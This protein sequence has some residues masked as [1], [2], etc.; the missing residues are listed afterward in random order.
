MLRSR[1]QAVIDKKLNKSDLEREVS[2]II[3]KSVENNNI[4]LLNNYFGNDAHKHY[5]TLAQLAELNVQANKVKMSAFDQLYKQVNTAYLILGFYYAC[6]QGN[7]AVVIYFVEHQRMKGDLDVG[8]GAVQKYLDNKTP[9]NGPPLSLAAAS[10]NFSLVSYLY[11]E[12]DAMIETRL[13]EPTKP[14][15]LM[16]AAS[17]GD[18]RMVQYLLENGGNANAEISYC[19][20]TPLKCAIESGN[21]SV[22][23]RLVNAGAIVTADDVTHAIFYNA[24]IKIISYLLT[25]SLN[26][27]HP[28]H[29]YLIT[30]IRSGNIDLLKYFE[31]LPLYNN[32][33]KIASCDDEPLERRMLAAA[34]TSGSVAMMRHLVE[35]KKLPLQKIVRGEMMEMDNYLKAN[36]DQP[37]FKHSRQ[38]INKTNETILY[39]ASSRFR[40]N[41][42]NKVYMLRYLFEEQN[43]KPSDRV[44]R[45]LCVMSDY[46]MQCIAYLLS[47]LEQAP[48]Q[49]GLL[50]AIAF[51]LEG[52]SLKSLFRIFNTELVRRGNKY[53]LHGGHNYV[54]KLNGLIEKKVS[55]L[56]DN[57]LV[58]LVSDDLNVAVGALFYF[59]DIKYDEEPEMLLNL[60]DCIVIGGNMFKTVDIQNSVG[61][62]LAQFA[63]WNGSFNIVHKLLQKGADPDFPGEKGATL[64]YTVLAH[65][66]HREHFD[67]IQTYTNDF[68]NSLRHASKDNLGNFTELRAILAVTKGE[69][70]KVS[71]A[72]L[73][74]NCGTD[75][76]HDKYTFLFR[77]LSEHN[78]RTLVALLRDDNFLQKIKLSKRDAEYTLKSFATINSGLTADDVKKRLAVTVGQSRDALFAA[79]VDAPVQEHHAVFEPP[80]PL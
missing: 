38:R 34:A 77:N 45:E 15:A 2:D 9:I 52:Q 66:G 24:S 18:D 3:K 60:I 46:D 19:H 61:E 25:I 32:L 62:T 47:H 6:Q 17:N 57:D 11:N 21:A 59:C 8:V 48:Y 26:Q 58:H 10:G 35:T 54:S 29:P 36:S 55:G 31:S 14:T 50:Q 78:A 27:E 56:S 49:I 43:L 65:A 64:A 68:S 53:E 16:I 37:G 75:Y 22:V 76:V 28:D 39:K 41:S 63:A 20:Q 70:G 44:L 79:P 71:V 1:V 12:T 51:D 23:E 73:V 7:L 42:K 13:D 30:A 80:R 40:S 72:E 33:E 5:L 4:I 67:W 69:T 74:E